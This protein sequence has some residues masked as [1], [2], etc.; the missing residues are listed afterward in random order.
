MQLEDANYGT[1]SVSFSN[2]QTCYFLTLREY[3]YCHWQTK[4]V[5]T[6]SYIV[7]GPLDHANDLKVHVLSNIRSSD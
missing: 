3:S 4:R 2:K 5:S 1:L 6:I 7:H